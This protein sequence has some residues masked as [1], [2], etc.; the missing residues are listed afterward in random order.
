MPHSSLD[1]SWC[2]DVTQGYS[3]AP[4]GSETESDDEDGGGG[5]GL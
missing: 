3:E 2:S 5:D 4:D 1:L